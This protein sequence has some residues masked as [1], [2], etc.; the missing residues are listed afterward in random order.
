MKRSY[1][2]RMIV[3]VFLFAASAISTSAFAVD[4]DTELRVFYYV[5]GQPVGGAVYSSCS[6][7]NR[8]WGQQSGALKLEKHIKCDDGSA[9]YCYWYQWTGS[10]WEL[11]FDGDCTPDGGPPRRDRPLP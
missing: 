3:A 11:I 7:W 5:N 6:G 10:E 4:Y 9:I 1:K 8:S 2:T